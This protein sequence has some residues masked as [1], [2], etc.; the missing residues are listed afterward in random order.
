MLFFQV[1]NYL[2]SMSS[3]IG[4]YTPQRYV[5]RI[6]IAL[7]CSPRYAVTLGYYTYYTQFHVGQRNH[8]YKFLAG[9]C[10]LLNS[11]EILALVCL[12]YISSIENFSKY[13]FL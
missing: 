12:T 4:G 6:C 3:A 13:I 8:I 1:G 7:H 5:W 2:P 10:A 9:L 11:I